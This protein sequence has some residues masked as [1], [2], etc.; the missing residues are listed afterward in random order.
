MRT[1]KLLKTAFFGYCASIF[2]GNFFSQS[3]FPLHF[4]FHYC[5]ETSHNNSSFALSNVDF[6]L[7]GGETLLVSALWVQGN[8]HQFSLILLFWFKIKEK[9]LLP[10][11]N[12][13]LFNSTNIGW[14]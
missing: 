8:K 14:L 2:V 7:E 13:T 10:D 6:S 11:F 4:L 1:F 9:L 3:D 5:S 12:L